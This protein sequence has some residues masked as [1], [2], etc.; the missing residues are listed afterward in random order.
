MVRWSKSGLPVGVGMQF[1]VR[2]WVFVNSTVMRWIASL[3]GVSEINSEASTF[4]C[5]APSIHTCSP[6]G[7]PSQHPVKSEL[8]IVQVTFVVGKALSVKNALCTI[9]L[10]CVCNYTFLSRC[11]LHADTNSSIVRLLIILYCTNQRTFRYCR[12]C[13]SKW[14]CATGASFHL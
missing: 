8:V 14:R 2:S 10:L 5:S 1:P 7:S 4:P 3:E 9:Y 13:C 6:F 11:S 12:F